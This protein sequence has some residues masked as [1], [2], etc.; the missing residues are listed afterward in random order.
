[1]G[2]IKLQKTRQNLVRNFFGCLPVQQ[3]KYNRTFDQEEF[4]AYICNSI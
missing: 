2:Q 1:M 3:S 4:L